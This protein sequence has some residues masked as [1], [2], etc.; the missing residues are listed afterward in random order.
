[1]FANKYPKLHCYINSI[2]NKD[3][4]IKNIKLITENIN[5]ILF[6]NDYEVT[7]KI[8]QYYLN[9]D[10]PLSRNSNVWYI[11]TYYASYI[12]DAIIAILLGINSIQCY[13][14]GEF[15][16]S[17]D[18]MIELINELETMFEYISDNIYYNEPLE[19]FK[20]IMIEL[21]MNNFDETKYEYLMIKRSKEETSDV[22]CFREHDKDNNNKLETIENE[23][24]NF[25]GKEGGKNI[26]TKIYD[27]FKNNI[28]DDEV[29]TIEEN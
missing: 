18:I 23:I 15:I 27:D 22:S 26:N 4:C 21:I 3:E 13:S 20:T 7:C 6:I 28:K 11:R 14:H 9:P 19:L 12:Y 17:S 1:M 16:I 29:N 5:N 10:T 25:S 24:D 8:S 2:K